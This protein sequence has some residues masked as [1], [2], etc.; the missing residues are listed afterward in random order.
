MDAYNANPSSMKSA[1][2]NFARIPGDN[3]VLLLG[4][5]AELGNESLSE[6]EILLDII[7]KHNWK[8]VVLVGGEFLKIKHSWLQ[9]PDVLP[10]VDWLKQQ[11]YE[12]TY[13]LIKGSRS[14]Q[15][16]KLADAVLA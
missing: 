5:M 12:N 16:E 1:I 13:F 14:I 11:R 6:H 9:F 8:Q 15:M 3:K 7:N 4:A 2:E 10:A